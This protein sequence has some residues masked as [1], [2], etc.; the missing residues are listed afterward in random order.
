MDSLPE[1]PAQIVSRLVSERKPRPEI[2]EYLAPV[3]EVEEIVAQIWSELLRIDQIGRDDNIFELGGD[4]LRMIQILAR[5]W[6]KLKVRIP[7]ETFFENLTVAELG[8][9]IA[10]DYTR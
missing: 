5:I 9:V 1:T 7:I 10:Q 4:S 2:G 6:R 3:G 8:V